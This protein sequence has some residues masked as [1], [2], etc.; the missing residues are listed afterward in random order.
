VESV[1]F[2]GAF[3]DPA[4]KVH[5]SVKLMCQCLFSILQDEEKIRL[6]V[7][8][9][10]AHT[11][12]TVESTSG[13]GCD[14]HLLGLRMML[15]NGEQASLFTD[16]AYLQSM[17]FKLTSSNVSLG[18]YFYGGFGPVVLGKYAACFLIHKYHNIRAFLI[19]MYMPDGYGVNYAIGSNRLRFSISS[20]RQ[21]KETCSRSFRKMLGESLTDLMALSTTGVSSEPQ[22]TAVGS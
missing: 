1:A 18:D 6:L 20:R 16:P 5:T 10:K 13:Y 4:I 19:N 22:K 7:E 9:L 2:V 14:R 21:S 12:L 11:K 15:Q 17:N 8:A 3:D